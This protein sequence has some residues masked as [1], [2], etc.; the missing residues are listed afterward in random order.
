M[1]YL[2]ITFFITTIAA[3]VFYLIYIEKK[4]LDIASKYLGRA[5]KCYRSKDYVGVFNHLN[6]SFIVPSNNL[7]SREEAIHNVEV[8]HL[9]DLVLLNQDVDSDVLT[10]ELKAFLSQVH[11]VVHID[12]TYFQAIKGLLRNS[13]QVLSITQ[14]N[15]DSLVLDKG[16]SEITDDL[17]LNYR[18]GVIQYDMS[19]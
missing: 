11:G 1:V 15:I 4:R 10:K 3:S 6:R 18:R 2:V 12:R 14:E 9:L 7:I 13:H 19:A 17:V 16:S 8:I 5:L